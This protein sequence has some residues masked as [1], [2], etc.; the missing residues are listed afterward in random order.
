MLNGISFI[1]DPFS[2][3]FIPTRLNIATALELQKKGLI[4][5]ALYHNYKLTEKGKKLAEVNDG[6]KPTLDFLHSL[7]FQ[8]LCLYPLKIH[9]LHYCI[10]QLLLYLSYK[11]PLPFLLHAV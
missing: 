10:L 3:D 6:I 2:D 11:I 4:E 7:I 5:E 8:L 9:H 1:K